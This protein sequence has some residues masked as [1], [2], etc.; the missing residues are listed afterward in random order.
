[1]EHNETRIF[2]IGTSGLVG[3]RIAA[4]LSPLF[5]ISHHSSKTGFDV[6]DKG[7]MSILR[8]DTNH[9]VVLLMAAKTD[10]DGCE[11]DKDEDIKILSNKDI[12]EQGERL[13]E[14]KTA[15]AV[16]VLGTQNVV[17]ACR[18]T[19]KK[20]IFVST[21]FVFNG[22]DTPKDG[23]DELH[24]PSP[25]NWYGVTKY[26]GEKIVMNS[27]LPYL[28]LRIAYPYRREYPEK[29]DFVRT[30]TAHLK[31]GNAVQGVTDHVMTPTFI[32][33]IAIALRQLLIVNQV[34]FFHVVGSEFI[35]PY[36]AIIQIAEKFHFDQS[37]ISKTTR[38]EYFKN[39]AHRPFNLALKND[40][41]ERLG[42]RMRTFSEGLEEMKR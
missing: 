24:T 18:E 4:L 27:G 14:A 16:N 19:N 17:D 25:I 12:K 26:E 9:E 30:V 36:D 35:S 2:G 28:I 13:R 3:S 34:G 42:V 11:T 15:W 6:T 38:S 23:Y 21:D 37:L 22:K 33:D 31:R 5:P 10:V 39:G 20:I 41:I 8:N 32:D 1:M 40:K 7:S 29:K